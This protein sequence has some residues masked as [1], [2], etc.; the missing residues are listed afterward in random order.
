MIDPLHGWTPVT[1]GGEDQ[2]YLVNGVDAWTAE[3]V[4]LRQRLTVAHP[5]YPSQQHELDVY[6]VRDGDR[7]AG[8]LAA[9]ELSASVWGLCQP[10]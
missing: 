4:P 9:G 6:E 3:W 2:N 5:A 1:I 7:R 10:A 8:F